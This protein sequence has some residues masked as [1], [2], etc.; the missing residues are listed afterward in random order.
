MINRQR[1]LLLI[2]VA[3]V[4][5][6]ALAMYFRPGVKKSDAVLVLCGGSMRPAME[7]IVARFK[8]A[9]GETVL[10]SYGDSS[11]F[12]VQLQNTQK[13]DIIV[14]HDPFMSW[15]ASLGLIDQSMNVARLDVVL[16][17]PKD[18]PKGIHKLEDLARPG[19]RVGAG[20]PK[21][22]TAGMIVDEM[23]R[24]VDYGPA[25]TKNFIVRTRGHQDLCNKVEMGN[26]DAAFVWNAVAHTVRDKV[27]II[28][29]PK[30][31]IPAI[32]IEP[33]KDCDLRKIN[34]A[35]GVTKYAKGNDRVKRFYDFAIAQ[36][37]VFDSLGFAPVKE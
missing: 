4:L 3:G 15:S 2:V 12:T 19:L 35:I 10:I 21:Y 22:S 11:E 32:R 27:S 16:I 5:A 1:I 24:L 29:I 18:N 9:T 8:K 37:D 17:V 25:V 33:Y 26:L 30:D 36:K 7:Q 6:A 23:L 28:V 34:V 20:D 31:K 13:G 14:C